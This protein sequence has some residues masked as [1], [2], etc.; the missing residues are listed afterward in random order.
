M[1]IITLINFVPKDVPIVSTPAL[2]RRQSDKMAIGTYKRN[3]LRVEEKS[4]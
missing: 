4:K 2:N 3:V 1:K